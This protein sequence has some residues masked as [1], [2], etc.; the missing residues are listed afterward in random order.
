MTVH[1]KKTSLIKTI[2]IAV[3]AFLLTSCRTNITFEM[4][5]DG[6]VRTEIIAEDDRDTMREINQTCS[7]LHTG[8]KPLAKFIKHGK[9]EDIT[10]PGGHIKCRLTSTEQIADEMKL[11]DEGKTY[12]IHVTPSNIKK[13]PEGA[14]TATSTIIMPGKVLKTTVG[15]IDGNKVVI[16]GLDY[17]VQGFTIV[18]E[19]SGGTSQS[20]P[21][22]SRTSNPTTDDGTGAKPPSRNDSG[23]GFPAWGWGL[24]GVGVLAVIAGAWLVLGRKRRTVH[25]P[26]TE[27]A[28]R[29]GGPSTLAQQAQPYAPGQ[30]ATNPTPYPHNAQAAPPSGYGYNAPPTTPPQA[31]PLDHTQD[32]DPN[33]RYRPR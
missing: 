22:A 14:F 4:H 26:T 10:S 15:K 17:S 2:L 28:Q 20:S 12:K 30:Q 13:Y 25:A 6:S 3:T 21:S 8:I 7:G 33:A 16:E 19:K 5:A 32:D 31:P 24:V 18:S 29:P 1:A 9:M 23:D 11:I 27:P